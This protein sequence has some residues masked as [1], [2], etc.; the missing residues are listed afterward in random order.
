MKVFTSVF[1]VEGSSTTFDDLEAALRLDHAHRKA[2]ELSQVTRRH[3]L[4]LQVRKQLW[5]DRAGGKA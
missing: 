5:P 3:V 2:D 4:E 1:V